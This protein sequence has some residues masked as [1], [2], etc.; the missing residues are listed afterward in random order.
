MGNDKEG[1]WK[2]R[3]ISTDTEMWMYDDGSTQICHL[4]A[5]LKTYR[6][7]SASSTRRAKA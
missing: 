4:V 1:T 3:T 5:L 2:R 7:R 6:P